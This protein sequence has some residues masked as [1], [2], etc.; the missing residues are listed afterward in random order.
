VLNIAVQIQIMKR[1]V[2][3]IFSLAI[4]S[5]CLFGSVG[6][7]DWM[8]AWV[9]LG[10]NFTSAIAT[11]VLLWRSHELLAERRNVRAGKSWDKAIVPFVVLVGPVAVWI[12]AAWIPGFTGRTVCRNGRSLPVWQQLYLPP[13]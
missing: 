9:L 13:L 3:I 6:R 8:N 12:T 11:T 5:G 2:P 4:T 1:L 10:L 7:L